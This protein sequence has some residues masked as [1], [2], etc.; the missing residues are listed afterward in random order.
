[1]PTS[2]PDSR[3]RVFSADRMPSLIV[4]REG[5]VVTPPEGYLAAAAALCREH[6]VW[7]DGGE[8]RQ[9][10][11][12]P[13]VDGVVEVEHLEAVLAKRL[14]VRAVGARLERV[15]DRVGQAD[16]AT[17]ARHDPVELLGVHDQA[18]KSMGSQFWPTIRVPSESTAAASPTTP[19]GPTMT[20]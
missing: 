11:H 3:A 7:L 6:G 18:L 2:A 8:L 16:H 15:A 13:L 9:G 5:G 4:E 10:L 1:M 17:D 20:S 14:G 12:H 19:N